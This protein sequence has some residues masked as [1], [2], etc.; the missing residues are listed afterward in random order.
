MREISVR[1]Q[2]SGGNSNIPQL[3]Q[4]SGGRA[5]N[6]NNKGGG[7]LQRDSSKNTLAVSERGD[8]VSATK[9]SLQ[10]IPSQQNLHSYRG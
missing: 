8:L 5:A 4:V 6:N 1:N 10:S 9:D 3:K 7:V 2:A